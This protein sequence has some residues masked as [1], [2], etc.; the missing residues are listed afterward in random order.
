MGSVKG[1][2]ATT[3]NKDAYGTYDITRGTLTVDDGV[4]GANYIITFNKGTYTVVY[5]GSTS[6]GN[7]SGG[8]KPTIKEDEELTNEEQ[9]KVDAI[10]EFKPSAKSK[11]TKLKN[12]KKAIRIT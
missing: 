8:Q 9:E 11:L 3:A 1:A 7:I 4:S 12:G 6:G 5:N 2:L 10:T